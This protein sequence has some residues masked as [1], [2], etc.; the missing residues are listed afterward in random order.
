LD[1]VGK[2]GLENKAWFGWNSNRKTIV[3]N[4]DAGSSKKYWVNERYFYKSSSFAEARENP[5]ADIVF[6]KAV[7]LTCFLRF[8]RRMQLH[9]EGVSPNTL[10]GAFPRFSFFLDL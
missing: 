3:R 2:D 4:Y 7:E 8:Y 6:Q 1:Y 5:V 9:G 10:L